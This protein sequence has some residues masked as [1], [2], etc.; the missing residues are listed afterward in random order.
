LTL[1]PY[2]QNQKCFID[3]VLLVNH[4]TRPFLATPIFNSGYAYA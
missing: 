4:V 2:E 1:K 3:H